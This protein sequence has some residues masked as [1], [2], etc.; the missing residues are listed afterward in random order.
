MVV[1][2]SRVMKMKDHLPFCQEFTIFCIEIEF[3]FTVL[4][5]K[6]LSKDSAFWWLACLT[7][8]AL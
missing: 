1:C 8:K 3:L 5:E 2:K 7:H 4:K 6:R